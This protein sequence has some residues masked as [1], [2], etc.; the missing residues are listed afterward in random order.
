MELKIYVYKK[1]GLLFSSFSSKIGDSITVKSKIIKKEKVE[2]KYADSISKGNA[3]IFVSDDPENKNRIIINMGNIPP[4]EEVIFTSEFLHL[5][6]A[7][8][9]EF[10]LLINFPIFDGIVKYKNSY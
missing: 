3:A 2:E 5:I 10:E 9:Y 8:S 7:K 1:N 6:E 4:K